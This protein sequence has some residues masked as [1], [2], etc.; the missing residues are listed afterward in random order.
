MPSL[1]T[2]LLVVPLAAAAALAARPH[3]ARLAA[4]AAVSLGLGAASLRVALALPIGAEADPL[5]VGALPLLSLRVD[6]GF[7]LLGAFLA[8]AAAGL[9]WGPDLRSRGTALLSGATG[10]TIIVALLPALEAAGVVP[11]FLATLALGAGCWVA[12]MLLLPLL[13]RLPHRPAGDSTHAERPAWAVL[14][15]LGAIAA[16]VAPHALVV[17]A[18][19]ALGAAAS[20]RI[21]VAIVVLPAIGFAGWWLHV[22]G[23]PTGLALSALPEGPFSPAAEAMLVPALA[24]A[25]AGLIAGAGRGR[26]G[27]NALLAVAG[28][29]LLLRIGV[30]ALPEGMDGW[31]TI[32]VPLGVLVMWAAAGRGALAPLALAGAWIAA[33]APAGGGPTGAWLLALVPALVAGGRLLS[34]AVPVR[35]LTSMVGALGGAFALDG[36]LRTEVVYGVVATAAVAIATEVYISRARHT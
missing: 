16:A 21:V 13:R 12:G 15:A 35:A 8:I 2:F 11:V 14:T 10:A 7:Q 29:A 30:P 18:G 20:R 36:V 5:W 6:A 3:G 25:A 19:A 17:L 23:A 1:L 33:F 22:I 9:A 32:A 26:P 27:S 24:V 28:I 31:R 34:R 4:L